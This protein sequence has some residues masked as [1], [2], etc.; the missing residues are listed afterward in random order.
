MIDTKMSKMAIGESVERVVWNKTM[1]AFVG[2]SSCPMV[3]ER[4]GLNI[5][6]VSFWLV[7]ETRVH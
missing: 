3:E 4:G 2:L 1:Y 7:T 5:L 6:A